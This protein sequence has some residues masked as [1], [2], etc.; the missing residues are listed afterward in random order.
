MTTAPAEPL[1]LRGVPT[2]Q[3][4]LHLGGRATGTSTGVDGASSPSGGSSAGAPPSGA[5]AA[6]I[7]PARSHSR[8]TCW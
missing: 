5:V 2:A 4:A 8:R 6:R 1:V 7:R 3:V